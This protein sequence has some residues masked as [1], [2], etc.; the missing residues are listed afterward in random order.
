M[1]KICTQAAYVGSWIYKSRDMPIWTG[2]RGQNAFDGGYHIYETYET[3]DGRY[4]TVGALE[5]QFYAELVRRLEKFGF[6]DI[7]EQYP[8]DAEQA[9]KRMVEIFRSKTRQQWQE[10]FDGTDACVVPVV[11]LDEA[12][13]HPHN[14]ARS[15]FVQT[16]SGHYEPAP[17]PKL[18]RTPAKAQISQKEPWIGENSIEILRQFG[19]NAADIDGL[20]KD[21]IV[22]QTPEPSKL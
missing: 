5:P 13:L 12:P 15:S 4:V 11:D 21:R 16:A 14:S 20:L 1:R 10:I 7:P 19:Y 8:D 6:Q 2:I 22:Y 3:S 18:S 17:A 9:K